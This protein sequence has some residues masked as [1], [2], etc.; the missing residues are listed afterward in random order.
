MAELTKLEKGDE[1]DNVKFSELFYGR[2]FRGISQLLVLD[3]GFRSL[4]NL[5]NNCFVVAVVY[6]GSALF[7]LQQ[8]SGINAVF[9]FSSTV[10][11]SAGVPSDIANMCV[12][13][14]N[15]LGKINVDEGTMQFHLL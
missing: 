10:F 12:G 9:Y 4:S 1:A 2:H 8:L 3:F 11:K 7:A 5:V 14:I 15:L 6:M 13:I